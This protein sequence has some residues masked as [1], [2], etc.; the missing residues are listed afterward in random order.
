MHGSIGFAT[1]QQMAANLGVQQGTVSHTDFHC[2]AAQALAETAQ[3][4][5]GNT[6]P[7][8][9]LSNY[10]GD[11][12]WQSPTCAGKGHSLV[13]ECGSGASTVCPSPEKH[14]QFPYSRRSSSF[15]FSPDGE[16]AQLKHEFWA[17]VLQDEATPG[18]GCCPARDNTA[19]DHLRWADGIGEE[20]LFH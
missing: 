8:A 19:L 13:S 11:S 18:A 16:E 12:P 2:M 6:L 9:S 7:S 17:L 5:L 20:E 4:P 15:D 3:A 1:L 14:Y 10:W